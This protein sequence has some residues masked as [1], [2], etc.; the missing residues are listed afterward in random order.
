MFKIN[1]LFFMIEVSM[2][3]IFTIVSYATFLVIIS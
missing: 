1:L 3:T 2:V